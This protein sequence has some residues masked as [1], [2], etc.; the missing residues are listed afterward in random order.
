MK[1]WRVGGVLSLLAEIELNTGRPDLAMDQLQRAI[2]LYSTR[3]PD[4]HATMTRTRLRL[5][6]L[7]CT[8]ATGSL[9]PDQNS[10]ITNPAMLSEA[11]A[12]ARAAADGQL[13]DGNEPMK[14]AESLSLIARICD[15]TGDRDAALD[16]AELALVVLRDGA[17]QA[18][19]EI[20]EA[21]DL[22]AR[23]RAPR[24]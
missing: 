1:G 24:T 16:A 22:V 21:R 9:M 14:R 15:L 19:I 3:F 20:K 8:A 6:K 4:H 13:R 10:K 18:A 23:L 12:L 5:A 7:L 17:P 2:E 11:L